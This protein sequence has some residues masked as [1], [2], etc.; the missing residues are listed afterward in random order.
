M[1]VHE[2][3]LREIRDR[4]VGLKLS[5]PASEIQ[6]R[7]GYMQ[8]NGD[9]TITPFTGISIYPEQEREAPGT[10]G[11]ED[12]GYGCGVAIILPAD[13]AFTENVGKALECRAKIRRKFVH[14][15]L[16]TVKLGDGYY[17]TTHVSHLP[18]NIP[19]EAHRY[20]A[21]S[22]LIRCWMREPRG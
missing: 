4:I 10:I 22:L 7:R 16:L 5:I 18:I 6:V 1:D 2:Q 19:R 3:C 17:L 8:Q 14:Q 21:S 9:R 13:H 11:K 20:E 15:K 12:I